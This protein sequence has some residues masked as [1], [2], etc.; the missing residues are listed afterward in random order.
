MELKFIRRV[1]ATAM[2]AATIFCM[3]LVAYATEGEVTTEEYEYEV[4]VEYEYNILNIQVTN[5][6]LDA[7]AYASLNDDQKRH[8]QIYQASL[9]NRSY[10]FGDRILVGN[11]AG[12]GMSYDIPPEALTDERFANM[13]HEAE[14]YLG[15]PYVWGGASPSTSFDC[16]GFV[17]WVINHCGNGWNYGRL[18]AD[19]L[20]GICTY[21]SPGDAKP[22]DLI[23][24]QGTYNT[25]GA[26]HVGIYVGNSMMIHCGDPI[27]YANI[28]TVYWQ[29]HFYTY[30]RL[31]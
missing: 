23:F 25:T 13:I 12:G 7:I 11:V 15:Y 20:R 6:G 2:A 19:G 17:S 26:S 30:G 16:S 18:T 27:T 5:K 24:F 10:L 29:S 22:G 1:F 14:K 9:G 4:E 21:V 31:P 8:Y 28:N 3:P